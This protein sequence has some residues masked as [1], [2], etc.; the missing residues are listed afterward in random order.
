MT[1]NEIREAWTMPHMA[2][3]KAAAYVPVSCCL[4]TDATGV[5]HC[6]HPAPPRPPWR[7][8]LRWRIQNRWS[9]L[10]MRAGSWVAGVD[11]DQDRE[12]S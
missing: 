5:N 6:Q 9:A 3:R 4:L 8:R 2:V 12:D 10:R 7:R 11:L 1:D